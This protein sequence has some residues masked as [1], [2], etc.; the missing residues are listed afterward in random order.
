MK[1][2]IASVT[3]RFA[4]A[5]AAFGVLAAALALAA[6]ASY[7]A[8]P[9]QAAETV[10]IYAD[11]C[12]TPRTEFYLGDTVCAIV[13]S[14]P[15]PYL[16]W[17]QRQFQW[18]TPN[19]RV[20]SQSDITS[21]RGQKD[22]FTIPASGEYARAGKW[23]VRTIDNEPGT[24]I[25]ANFTVRNPRLRLVDLL[26]YQQGPTYILPGTKVKYSMTIANEGLDYTK[27]V[28]FVVEVPSGMGFY[29]LKQVSGGV[30]TCE[31]P[32]RGYGG[33]IYC[34]SDVMKAEEI[35][36]FDVYYIVDDFIKEGDVSYGSAHIWSPSEEESPDNNYWTV[37]A[38]V[39][40]RDTYETSGDPDEPYSEGGGDP[41]PKDS[42]PV[43][44]TE[45]IGDQNPPGSDPL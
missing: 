26:L 31:L 39:V 2:C 28:E 25:I 43:P 14:A 22:L 6:A 40:S 34:S 20:T 11:D 9:A 10:E 38:A 29:T 36:S 42:D 44:P 33:R 24:Q 12:V 4:R 5:R 27:G 18:V 15:A 45:P 1:F 35:A 7:G 8:A 19:Q 23:S 32:P 30:F 16:G 17:R 3:S 41:Y 13:R 37:E 21:P